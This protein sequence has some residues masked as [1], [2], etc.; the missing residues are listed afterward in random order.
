[1]FHINV[2]MTSKR[3]GSDD[4]VKASKRVK[5]TYTVAVGEKQVKYL[6]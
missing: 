4:G 5:E 6:F 3:G 1:M 2:L